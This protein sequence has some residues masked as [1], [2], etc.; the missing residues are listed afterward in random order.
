MEGERKQVTVLFA[1]VVGSTAMAESLDPEEC[2]A[3][4]RRCFDLMLQEVHRYE[5]TVTQFLGDGIMALFGAP[6]AREDHALSAVRAALGIQSALQTYQQELQETQGIRLRM[7]VGLNSGL[8]VV[9]TIGSDLSMT[10]TAIGDTVNLANRVQ[11]LGEPGA[12]V[13]SQQTQRLVSGYFITRDLGEHPVKGKE[14][15]VRVYEV[16]GASRFRSRVAVAAERGL[17][18]FV[19]RQGDRET[20]LDRWASARAGRGQILFVRGEPGIGKSRLLHEFKTSMEGENL[21]RF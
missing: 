12:V 18:R 13:I 20:L 6:I 17:S 5:G 10:Y 19:G 3:I 8:V 16:V 9:G 1:D 14:Q 11:E 21:D 4:M 7:R 2:Q 15:A